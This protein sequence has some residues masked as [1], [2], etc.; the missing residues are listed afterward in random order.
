MAGY[1]KNKESVDNIVG[2][3][4]QSINRDFRRAIELKGELDFYDDAALTSLGYTA[5]EVATLRTLATNLGQLY[6]IYTGTASLASAKDF[7]PAL[8][9]VWGILGDF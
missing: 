9:A 1:P 3:L 5:G 6:N 4:A 8:R 2:E 7:R